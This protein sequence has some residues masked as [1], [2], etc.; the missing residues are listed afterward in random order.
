MATTA[1]EGAGRGEDARDQPSEAEAAEVRG[2]A[3]DLR[4]V[5]AGPRA[6]PCF[7]LRQPH[8]RRGRRRTNA[9]AAQHSGDQQSGQR[10]PH[11]E[12]ESGDHVQSDSRNQEP[13]ATG[14]VREVTG[15][16]EA[17]RDGDRV[18]GE[19]DEQPGQFV[20]QADAAT[21]GDHVGPLGLLVP[22]Q[23][24]TAF[25]GSTPIGATIIGAI[26]VNALRTSVRKG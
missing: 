21:A 11:D 5:T 26:G 23:F 7:E 1:E 12:H 3:D 20:E 18:D 8:R 10:G 13:T 2:G 9:K 22:V 25:V 15:E 16:D 19:R 14:R 17:D 4:S 24:A 6:P